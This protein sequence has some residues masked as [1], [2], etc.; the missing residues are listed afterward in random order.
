MGVV[1]CIC[2]FCFVSDCLSLVSCY[3]WR[4]C[5]YC[6][7]AFGFID[8]GLVGCLLCWV[9]VFCGFVDFALSLCLIVLSGCFVCLRFCWVFD[10][11][12][13]FIV[14]VGWLFAFAFVYCGCCLVF[15]IELF[16]LF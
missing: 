3:D 8:E 16:D 9:G 2:L 15:G 5:G 6:C 11:T 7:L 4:F 14:L 12:I 1:G 10:F 13:G